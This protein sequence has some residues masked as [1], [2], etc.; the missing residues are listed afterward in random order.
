[1]PFAFPC[2]VAIPAL[3]S[4]LL[5]A[6]PLL[7]SAAPPVVLS[8]QVVDQAGMPVRDAVVEIVA[9]AGDTR[10][11]AFPWRNAMAQKNQTFVPGTLIVPKGAVVAF[12]NFDSVRHSIYSFSKPGPF[13]I[14]LYGQDQ[15]RTQQFKLAGTIALG[16]NIHDKMQGYIR[17]TDTP[18]AARTDLNGLADVE[19]LGRGGYD[20]VVW[21]PRIRGAG[22]EWRGKLVMQPGTRLKVVVPVRP[23]AG[24]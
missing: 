20:V 18:Y 17:V 15:T 4:G 9:P 11:L 21:H 3:P 7:L 8:V 22:G 1:M 6:A 5:V 19:G 12:P 23:G 10:R 2:R 16:C 13:K 14:D 24:K